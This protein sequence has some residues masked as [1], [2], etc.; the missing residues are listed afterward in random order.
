M[1]NNYSP[2]MKRRNFLKN[3]GKF[4]AVPLIL[5]GVPLHSFATPSM[6][7]LLTCQGV[8]ERILVIVFLKGGN[9]GINTIVPISQYSTYA[10]HRP[11]IA[12]P[13][14]TLI[15]LDTTLAAPDQV[16]LHPV[17]TN[18]KSM[19][20]SGLAGIVQAVGY[21][22][23]N[24]S[25]F[26]STDLW[27]TGGDGSSANFNISSGWMGR[28]IESAWPG[29]ANNPSSLFPDPLGIQFGDTKPSIG[30][31]DFGNNYIGTN[32]T[33]QDPAALFGLLNGLGTAPHAT[34]LNTEYFDE[35]DYIMNVENNTNAYGA[36]ITNVYNSGSNSST[37]YPGSKL[38]EQL[39]I[40]ARLISGGITT[41]IFLV[42]TS[43]FDNHADQ[44]IGGATTTGTHASLLTDVFDSI[45]AFHDDLTN[46]MVQERVLTASFF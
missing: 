20:D 29:A 3:I 26:K 35:I 8:D 4:S 42:H 17:M 30:L 14:G 5:N 21:P 37:T 31:N 25:H 16:G 46:L 18:F 36:R 19:Y 40:I 1:K 12:L 34:T 6:L 44:V 10:T 45:K 43:G 23:Y 9:D 39:K 32:L 41:K 13:S 27:L 2:K 24:H 11:S 38:A 28:F 15:N 22:I 7:P 33:G